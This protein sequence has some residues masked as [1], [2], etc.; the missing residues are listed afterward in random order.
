MD[1]RQAFFV[2]G[3]LIADIDTD[4]VILR[5]LPLEVMAY[6]LIGSAPEHFSSP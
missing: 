6:F 2:V 5:D 1:K 3:P 4:V